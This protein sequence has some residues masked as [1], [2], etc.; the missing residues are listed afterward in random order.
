M[1]P[2]LFNLFNDPSILP[3]PWPF[4][5]LL[6]W[7]IAKKRNP[8]A[9]EIYAQIGGQSPILANTQAQMQ[10][11]QRLLG[12]QY[13]LRIAMRYW[14]PF[15]KEALE[16]VKRDRPDKIVLLPLYPQYSSTTSGSSIKEWHRQAKENGL[17]IPL[18]TIC[19]YP[20]QEGFLSALAKAARL[21]IEAAKNQTGK[22][23]FVIFSAHGL[24]QRVIDKGDP[25][26][27]QMEE[28]ASH[29]AQRLELE[30]KDWQLCYQSKV[31]RLKWLEPATDA[32]IAAKAKEGSAIVVVPL[33]FVSEHSE[34]LVELDIEYK[35][36]AE[37]MGATGYWRVPTVGID[38]DFIRGLAELVQEAALRSEALLPGG[39]Q[40]CR[41]K[42]LCPRYK[43]QNP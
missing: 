36:L 14:H 27:A 2:F 37:E 26:Q 10:A 43:K 33:A 16:W 29:L 15:T 7:W 28:S 30:K 3:L 9:Q 17:D 34:T 40:I 4:R 6:A 23:P 32:V 8:F 20:L 22:M 24:P 31:G 25:Y 42:D 11:L 19:C 41:A 39:E 35:K 21:R 38:A 18:T 12:P 5:S 13:R 1:R